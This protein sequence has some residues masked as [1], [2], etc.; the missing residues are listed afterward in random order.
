MVFGKKGASVAP[1]ANTL[2]L[3]WFIL[4]WKTLGHAQR[5]RSVIVNYTDNL[6][7]LVRP[8][9][10]RDGRDADGGHVDDDKTHTAR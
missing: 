7:S 9:G 4:D 2:T 5:F 8:D 3:Q 1:L 10:I 6:L